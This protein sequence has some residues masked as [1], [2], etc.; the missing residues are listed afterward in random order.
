MYWEGVI[1]VTR[2][3]ADVKEFLLLKPHSA[4]SASSVNN[5]A[6]LLGFPMLYLYVRSF[7]TGQHLTRRD[8]IHTLPAIFFSGRLRPFLFAAHLR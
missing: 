1:P 3:N 8:L 6:T 4:E 5:L 7:A 2:L